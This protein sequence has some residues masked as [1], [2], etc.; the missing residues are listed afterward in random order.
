MDC[1]ICLDPLQSTED[2]FSLSCD[3][4]FHYSCY[5]SLAK[6]TG[7]TFVTCPLCREMNTRSPVLPEKTT[8]ENL[9]LWFQS[10][11]Q[12]CA[13]TTRGQRCKHRA[14][15]LNQGC[16]GIHNP[17]KLPSEK[18]QVY[19]EYVWYTLAS[20][21]TWA[22][23]I[24]MFD[25]VRQLLVQNPE[26]M[27]LSD[28]F[29]YTLQFFQRCYHDGEVN[30]ANYREKTNPRKIYDYYGLTFPSKTWIRIGH[31]DKEML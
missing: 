28:I 11:T 22:T 27:T 18:Y 23:K 26:I 4:T 9:K 3:H 24:Y 15:F 7:H 1:S 16:C 21:N 6:Q 5:A 14:P 8:E 10:G 17:R 12:C 31:K 25:I 29:Q 20:T 13:T 30:V 2:L 19:S